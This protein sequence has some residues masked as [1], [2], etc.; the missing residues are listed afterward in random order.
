MEKSPQIP[1][2]IKKT[3]LPPIPTPKR[4]PLLKKAEKEYAWNLGSSLDS[5]KVKETIESVDLENTCK[6]FAIALLKHV[7]FSKGELLVDDL[8]AEEEDIPQF[9]YK[10]GKEL[11]IDLDEI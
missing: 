11:K 7:E 4:S 9:S 3:F 10:L 1:Q 5:K 2:E 6:C 8:V